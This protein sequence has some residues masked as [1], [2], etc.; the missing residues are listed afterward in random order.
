M[1][2]QNYSTF[3]QKLSEQTQRPY[4]VASK[5]QTAVTVA[6]LVHTRRKQIGAQSLPAHNGKLLE[7][8]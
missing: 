7:T 1:N 6:N 2:T 5:Q 4:F 3:P 8:H